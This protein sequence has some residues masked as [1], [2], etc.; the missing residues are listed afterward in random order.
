ME[1]FSPTITIPIAKAKQILNIQM[2]HSHSIIH[3]NVHKKGKENALIGHLITTM[4]LT[5]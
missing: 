4:F 3:F 5:Y 1:I 2:E